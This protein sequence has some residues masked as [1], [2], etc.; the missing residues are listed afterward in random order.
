MRI[1]LIVLFCFIAFANVDAQNNL[2]GTKVTTSSYDDALKSSLENYT[3]F[4]MDVLKSA[5]DFESVQSLNLDL[6]SH[7]FD[8]TVYP[9]SVTVSHNRKNLPHLLSGHSSNG[10]GLN[11]T[12][13][14]DFI[15]G[16]IKT[17]SSRLFMEPLRYFD[18]SAPRNLFVLYYDYDVIFNEEHKCGV[19][20]SDI[21][22]DEIDVIRSITDECI[23]IDYALANT[24]DMVLEFGTVADVE[25]FNLGVLNT[26]QQN[27]RSE[28]DMNVE[29]NLVAHF[30]P[31]T[32]GAD[33]FTATAD[34]IPLLTDFANW[35]DG[36]GNFG[37]SSGG[38]GVNYQM[39]GL[40]TDRDIFTTAGNGT[41]GIA[42]TPGWHHVFENFTGNAVQ[43][44]V[45]T[46]HEVGHNFSAVHDG[47]GSGFIMA[48]AVNGTE[49]WS[50]PSVT[51]IQD[52]VNSQG[53]LDDCSTLGPPVANFNQSTIITCEG[54]VVEFEDQSQYGATRVWDFSNGTPTTSTNEKVSVTYN[55]AGQHYV[56]VTS[57]NGA[58]SSDYTYY[59]DVQDAPSNPC[60]PT[61]TG[62]NGGIINVSLSNVSN[63]S[64]DADELRA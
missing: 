32:A 48:P 4:E 10:E 16:Y 23:V 64:D 37:G 56:K 18:Q 19:E 33:P 52:R 58:G 60:F 43:L 35:A 36:G 3:I 51:D 12:I 41:V 2:L 20:T 15:F 9:N 1:V 22:T 31:A 27:Y 59:V 46:S 42:Y 57:T 7:Q 53:Y 25:D 50:G 8:L 62:G 26:M 49:I 13:N 6:G 21:K 63:A 34:A 44:Q 61:G 47:V 29:F 24:H 28:F 54:S 5:L 11:L 40:W 38:F 17:G 30:T 55:T 14:D 39:A 45:M